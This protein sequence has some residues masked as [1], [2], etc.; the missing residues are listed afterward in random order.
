MIIT[1]TLNPAVDRIMFIDKLVKNSTNRAYKIVD[2]LG[3]KGTHVSVDLDILG[4]DST[5]FGIDYGEN[6]RKIEKMLNGGHI[7]EEFL[8]F[9]KG[10]SRTNYAIIESNGD[11]SMVA[12]H[13]KMVSADICRELVES[14]D[15]KLKK[16]DCLV[17]SGDASNTEIPFL[18]G[19]LT[20]LGSR[21]G[22]KVFLDTSAENLK[23][24]IEKRPFLVKPNIEELSQVIGN[25]ITAEKEIVSGIHFLRDKGISCVALT[26]GENGSY[27]SYQ[28]EIYRVESVR[29]KAVNTIGCGD[30]F[31]SGMVYG[32]DKGLDIK[33]TISYAA[34]ISLATAESSLT[35]GY[36]L[37]RAMELRKE[38]RIITLH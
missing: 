13:G 27:I 21:K 10:E 37:S 18:Y 34:A 32:F 1:V 17:L 6:G 4:Y 25:K 24:A 23:K 3:G 5:A 35:V 2:V 8:H 20:S 14:I 22:A 33:E 16:D 38:V 28:D 12:E 30:A 31:L 15:R 36:D 7:H 29:V 11:C 19:E 9:D 26:C